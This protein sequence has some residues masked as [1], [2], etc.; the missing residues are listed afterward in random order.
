MPRKLSLVAVALLLTALTGCQPSTTPA[1]K[2]A[3]VAAG[4]V[5]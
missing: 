5:A 4:A 2:A 3:A 1:P